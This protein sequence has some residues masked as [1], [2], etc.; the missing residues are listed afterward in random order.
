[1]TNFTKI[2]EGACKQ[3]ASSHPQN[4]RHNKKVPDV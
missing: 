1:M 3:Q 4:M 2:L